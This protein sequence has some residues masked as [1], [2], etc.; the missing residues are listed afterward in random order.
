VSNDA[1]EHEFAHVM[2]L[3]QEQMQELTAMEQKRATLTATGTAA[4]GTVEVTVDA[5]RLV[6]ST[7]ID[8]SYLDDFEFAD[9]GGYITTA[10]QAAGVEIEQ[11]S[12]AL[13]AP[14]TQRRE[15]ISSASGSVV[16][17]PDFQEMVS[18]LRASTT[19]DGPMRTGDAGDA[20]AEEVPS[21]PTVRR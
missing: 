12:A 14:L 15:E 21:F 4:D 5:Q 10:A 16:D 11:R 9:L 18:G 7:V 6:T 3:V 17:I 20:G 19:V 8:E 13:L 1:A 2:A